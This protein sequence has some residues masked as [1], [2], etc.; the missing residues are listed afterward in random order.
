MWNF[1]LK[2]VI[3]VMYNFI[4]H[5]QASKDLRFSKLIKITGR[6]NWVL[7]KALS[8]I[9]KCK[10]V[11]KYQ[12]Q[13]KWKDECIIR[14][15]HC[16]VIAKRFITFV[17]KTRFLSN[18]GCNIANMLLNMTLR[19]LRELETSSL[20]PN[21]VNSGLSVRGVLDKLMIMECNFLGLSFVLYVEH[22]D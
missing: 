8:N 15:E 20:S 9:L 16:T 10:S 22:Y 14:F 21:N 1:P 7:L 11:A 18:K 3:N 2:W 4:K 13:E 19:R 12:T 5:G 6:K 17:S